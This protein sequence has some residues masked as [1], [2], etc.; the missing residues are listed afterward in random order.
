MASEWREVT[1]GEVA[2]FL[3][4]GTPSKGH[5]EYWGGTIPWVELSSILVYEV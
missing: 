3:S 5:P 1:L 4:G 2:D